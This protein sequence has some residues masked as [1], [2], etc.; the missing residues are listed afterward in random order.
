MTTYV[1]AGGCFWCIDAVYR[2]LKGVT[3]VE[4][5]Y[6]NG[7]DNPTNYYRVASGTTGH[8]EAVRITF[9]ETI[10]PADVILDIFFLIHNPT[11]LNR[12]GADTGTQYR[13]SLMYLDEQQH[14]GFAA[15]V[16]RAKKHWDDPIVTE[17]VPLTIFQIAE[18]EHQDFFAK[19]PESGYCSIVI[20]PK[21]VK[22]RQRYQSWFKKEE[23]Y[24]H[25]EV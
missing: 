7:H 14:S 2:Q 17:I 16:E 3:A 11:T 9:D 5:G 24:D 4:S 21:I 6:A 13:S 22:A 18:P 20:L 1:L 15:A 10:I 12:Q 23:A 8:A 25:Y 19:Q